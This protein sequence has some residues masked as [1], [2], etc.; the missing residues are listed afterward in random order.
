MARG[1]G[2]KNIF[3][4]DFD[5]QDALNRLEEVCGSFGWRVHA[6]VLMGNHFHLLIETPEPNLVKGMKWFMG[7]I[8]SRS[9]HAM[10]LGRASSGTPVGLAA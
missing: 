7:V 8:C 10:R 2:G 3:E 5:R 4:S 6:W 1:D 9:A